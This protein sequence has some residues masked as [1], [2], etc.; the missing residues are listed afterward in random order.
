MKIFIEY[1]NPF[2]L[3]EKN[4]KYTHTT[5]TSICCFDNMKNFIKL[6]SF[7]MLIAQYVSYLKE[8]QTLNSQYWS[9][10]VVCGLLIKMPENLQIYE[11]ICLKLAQLILSKDIKKYLPL[12][13]Q[14]F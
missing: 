14:S 1:Y 13:S 9:R 8:T 10:Y 12:Y 11:N 6:I 4:M 3:T 2:W 5:P 7:T